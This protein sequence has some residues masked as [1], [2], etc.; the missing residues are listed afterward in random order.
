MPNVM[1][2]IAKMI[3][4]TSKPEK[5]CPD[6]KMMCAVYP[7]KTDT[8][9]PVS[10]L[11]QP[12]PGRMPRGSGRIH[13]S[14]V[15]STS[16]ALRSNF[17]PVYRGQPISFARVS[18]TRL[19]D[20]S[21]SEP[22]NQSEPFTVLRQLQAVYGIKLIKRTDTSCIGGQTTSPPCHRKGRAGSYS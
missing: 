21:E 12:D 16:F 11:G 17:R 3:H 22:L 7:R 5:L 18:E 1:G 10:F 15:V 14:C 9:V 6:S 4:C 8:M 13:G 20:N 19:H 2:K